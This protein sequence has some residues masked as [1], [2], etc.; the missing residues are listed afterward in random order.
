MIIEWADWLKLFLCAG[1]LAITWKKL[2]QHGIGVWPDIGK[3]KNLPCIDSCRDEQCKN[4]WFMRHVHLLG[5]RLPD[6]EVA[7]GD[8][9]RA[10]NMHFRP[11]NI[12][13]KIDDESILLLKALISE[14]S[15]HD[16]VCPCQTS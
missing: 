7:Y 15:L 16:G 3:I 4:D 6:A 14:H 13:E 9:V 2:A 1:D 10:F 12:D 5:Y 8:I 11:E